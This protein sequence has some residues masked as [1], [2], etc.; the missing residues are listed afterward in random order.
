MVVG[1]HS[2]EMATAVLG[3]NRQL[4][5]CHISGGRQM[6]RAPT[7]QCSSYEH[8]VRPFRTKRGA[9]QTRFAVLGDSVVLG[10]NFEPN[11]RTNSIKQHFLVGGSHSTVCVLA[12]RFSALQ[13]CLSTKNPSEKALVQLDGLD[14]PSSVVPCPAFQYETH[15][16]HTCVP[17]THKLGRRPESRREDYCRPRWGG[18]P[19]SSCKSGLT[20]S[21]AWTTRSVV[22]G[23]LEV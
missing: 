4:L 11:G 22:I 17:D 1:L 3:R 14:S 18:A 9:C 19:E 10:Q 12:V 20:F 21:S 13:Y 2:I 23:P 5:G 6:R 15:F 16:P 7:I 8:V